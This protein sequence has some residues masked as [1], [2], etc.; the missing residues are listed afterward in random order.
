MKSGTALAMAAMA[1]LAGG[2]VCAQAAPYI[3]WESA[4]DGLDIREGA[5][6][7]SV[8]VGGKAP[9]VYAAAG[10]G[11]YRSDD[12]GAS[13]SRLK[14]DA[15]VVSGTRWV[16][17]A[18]DDGRRVFAAAEAADG[19]LYRSMDGGAT[20]ARC[21]GLAREDVESVAICAQNPQVVLAGHR[22]GD[23]MSSSLDGGASWTKCNMGGPVK[24]QVVLALDEARWVVVGRAEDKGIRV[25]ETGGQTWAEGAGDVQHHPGAIV[26]A[27][28]GDTL[29]TTRHHGLNKSTDG[30]R[31]WKYTMEQHT[32]M[33][34]AAGALLFREGNREQREGN[35]VWILQMSDNEGVSWQDVTL[36]LLDALAGHLGRLPPAFADMS[37]FQENRQATAWAAAA[38]GQTVFLGLG[39]AGLY[40]GRLMSTAR[41]PILGGITLHPSA[42]RAG[43]TTTRVQIRAT[44]SSRTDKEIGRAH[45]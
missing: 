31:T 45:V 24:G 18:P 44:A 7:Q 41:G 12:L 22:D 4:N 28:S 30:G 35:R 27:R 1:C 25:S 3:R 5:G 15:P 26:V 32:R 39:A 2:I 19:G 40:R 21:Q 33:V 14:G 29:L 9:V 6:V 36:N 43:D 10:G 8:A 11:L 20:W 34:G 42:V 37:P 23:V 17:A 38:D 13:W 16:A